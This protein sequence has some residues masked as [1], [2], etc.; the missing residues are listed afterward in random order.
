M[1]EAFV[2]PSAKEKV[3]ESYDQ[4]L[5]MWG[6]EYLEKDIPTTCGLTHCIIAGKQE[7]PPLVLFHGVGDNSAVMW[8]LNIGEWSKKFYCIAVDTLGGPGKSIPNEKFDKKYFS[9][10]QWINEIADQLKLDKFNVAG[11][12]N[13]ALM[14]FNYTVNESDRVNKAVCIEGGIVT[15]PMKSMICTLGMMFPEILIPTRNNM[16]NIL[17]KLCSPNSDIFERHPEVID[18]LILLMHSHNRKAMFVHNIAKYDREKGIASKDKLYFL[19]GRH[20]LKRRSKELQVLNEDHYRYKIIEN[21]GHALNHE[22]F[23]IANKEVISF[24]LN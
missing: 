19:I 13:G 23:E 21:A 2:N 18:H 24:I 7:N 6:V 15:S 8:L 17:A 1:M 12:S 9:Q 22:Q 3:W 16:R 4:L 10:I 20:M 14:A 5:K 11:V